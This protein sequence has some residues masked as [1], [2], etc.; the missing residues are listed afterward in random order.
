M[1]APYRHVLAVPGARR[2]LASALVARMPQGMSGLA[3]LLLVRGATH[4]YALAGLAVGAESLAVAASA[5]VLGRAIDRRGRLWV[6]SRCIVGY[7]LTNLLLVVAASARAPGGVLVV[8]SGCVGATLP[9]VAPAVRALLR[10][11]FTDVSVRESAYALESVAQEL[12][13]VT[14]PLV[15]A[16]VIAFFPPAVAVLLVG[17]VGALGTA[18]F[19]RVPFVRERREA[20]GQAHHG[21]ALASRPLRLLLVP[22]ALTGLGLGSTEVG[23]PALALHVGSRSAAGLLL[24]LWS[25]GSLLGGLWYGSRSWRASL[26]ARYRGL[27]LAAVVCTAPLVAADSLFAGTVCSL[28]AGLAIAPVFSCQYTLVGH[29]VIPGTETEAFTW[30]SAA[31]VAGLS[32]GSA[33]GGGL[34]SAA[35]VSAPFAFSCAAAA[36]AAALAWL[37]GSSAVPEPALAQA[38]AL[39]ADSA[40]AD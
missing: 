23:L 5:P 27:L 10:D 35:G 24:A 38:A 6:F 9:P 1:L 31:L 29:A 12:V 11:V 15:V 16:V 34:V 26:P 25:L 40:G 14:G 28:L 7:A 20:G 32:A 22:V 36:L 13:W 21:R 17:A 8:L 2:L 3:V 37:V 30:V 39:A 19:V 33:L 4:S 18:L